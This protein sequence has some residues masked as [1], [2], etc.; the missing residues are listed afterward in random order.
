MNGNSDEAR[1]YNW[2][3]MQSKALS[4][5]L[6]GFHPRMGYQM[7]RAKHGN[8]KTRR[9]RQTRFVSWSIA[10]L[11]SDHP[12]CYQINRTLHT[13][14]H[15]S[16][17]DPWKQGKTWAVDKAKDPGRNKAIKPD[18]KTTTELPAHN[19]VKSYE[20]MILCCRDAIA[21]LRY[22]SREEGRIRLLCSL[23]M[24]AQNKLRHTRSTVPRPQRGVLGTHTQ[25]CNN[26]SSLV[27]K[28]YGPSYMGPARPDVHAL[29]H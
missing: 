27:R 10:K 15:Q 13:T 14:Q 17:L 11:A 25:Y 8:N 21:R 12:Y 4:S 9:M 18:K 23:N 29:K 16:H 20:Y 7:Q 19:N 5:L 28:N 6:R 2:S 1:P 24:C 3:C 26:N 22:S